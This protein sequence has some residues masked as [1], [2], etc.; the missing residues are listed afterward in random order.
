MYERLTYG[1]EHVHLASLDG[2]R[3][4][5]LTLSSLGK[6]FSLTG[7]KVGWAIGPGHLTAGVRAA[8]QFL[9]FAVPTPLQHGAAAALR[10]G[11]DS[12]LELVAHY[13]AMRDLLGAALMR[14]GFDVCRPEGSYFI[15][16]DHTGLSAR[17]GL[18]DDV[19]L[20]RYLTKDVGVAAIPPSAFYSDPADGAG[21]VRF[22]IC[23]AE[24]TMRAAIER[25][26]GLAK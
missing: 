9:T 4:R 3:E 19:E 5:T 21:F 1:A 14:V 18:R 11:G 16:A 12:V 15:M 24:A 7:W 10:E 20:C 2:M 26:E 22:A 23:K 17:L 13:A 6:T 25:L 8:H